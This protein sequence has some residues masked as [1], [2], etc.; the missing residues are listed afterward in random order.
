M[1]FQ[2][3]EKSSNKNLYLIGLSVLVGLTAGIL[4]SLY[5]LALQVAENLG[6][7]WY[8]QASKQPILLFVLIPIILLLVFVITLLMKKNF[9]CR[10]DPVFHKSRDYSKVPFSQIG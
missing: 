8:G 1:K 3:I 6:R 9:Q 5:R 10:V 7:Y 4:A 2:D